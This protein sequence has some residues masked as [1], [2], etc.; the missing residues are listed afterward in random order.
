[1]M[2]ASERAGS[3]AILPGMLDPT[4]GAA[5]NT[6]EVVSRL[7]DPPGSRPVLDIGAGRGNFTAHL[8]SNGYTA[9]AVDIDIDDY[10]NAGYS[11]A[12]FMVVDL[13]DRIPVAPDSA[14]G[15]IA[16]EVLEHLEAPLRAMRLIAAGVSLGGFLIFTTPNVMSWGSRLELLVRGHHEYF[17]AL[18]YETNG[19]ISPVS[20]TQLLRMGKRLGLTPE[21]V[22]YN[23]GRLPIPRLHQIT[24][25]RPRFRNGALGESLIV[26]FRKT[27]L[28]LD[29]Y[30]RG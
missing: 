26:K 6:H 8:L 3:S 17:G 30:V 12:P 10:S 7:L 20:L 21:A 4:A 5:I 16:I 19:H 29:Q 2:A 15:A 28:P 25:K 27:A 22:T 18:E 24:L 9:V 11:S 1:M 14:A 13:D 23:V